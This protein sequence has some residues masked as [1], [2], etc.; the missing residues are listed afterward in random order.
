MTRIGPIMFEVLCAGLVSSELVFHR[1]QE[2]KM[3]KGVVLYTKKYHS[4]HR[5]R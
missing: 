5:D 1:L 2:M 3:E 4:L